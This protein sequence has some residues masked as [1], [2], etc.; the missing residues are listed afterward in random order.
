MRRGQAEPEW[1]LRAF[2]QARCFPPMM[3]GKIDG[4]RPN[5]VGK[6]QNLC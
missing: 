2:H 6:E 1:C 5:V 3:Q 4:V